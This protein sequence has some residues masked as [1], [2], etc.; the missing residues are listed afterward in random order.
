MKIDGRTQMLA[1]KAALSETPHI[2][3]AINDGQFSMSIEGDGKVLMKMLGQIMFNITQQMG[4][5]GLND[6]LGAIAVAMAED[7]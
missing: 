1:V 4:L 3:A 5:N 6:L 7:L 2:C